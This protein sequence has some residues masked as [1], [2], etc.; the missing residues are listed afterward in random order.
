MLSAYQR[1]LSGITVP[2]V[3]RLTATK[4]V[5]AGIEPAILITAL[6]RTVYLLT[7]HP[8]NCDCT[9]LIPSLEGDQLFSF[10]RQS[11]TVNIRPQSGRDFLIIHRLAFTSAVTVVCSLLLI[12]AVSRS[13]KFGDEELEDL[14]GSLVFRQQP[15]SCH[16]LHLL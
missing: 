10:R 16:R 1:S 14:A 2:C 12:R 11:L 7:R 15:E 4:V 3:L 6:G 8:H 9:Y 5:E 13:A